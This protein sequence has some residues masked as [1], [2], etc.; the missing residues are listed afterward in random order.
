MP[1]TKDFDPAAA[2]DAAMDLFWTKGYEATS[3]DDL[4]RHLGVGR[5]SLYATFGSKH[6][7]YLRALERYR[8]TV[9]GA[10]VAQ[11]ACGA[12]IRQALRVWLAT[13]I[14]SILGDP[15][16]RGCIMVNAAAE[17][18]S[19]DPAARRCVNSNAQSIEDALHA[20]IVRA[21]QAGDVSRDKDARALAR[22]YLVTSQGLAL[23]A[24]TAERG[25]LQDT[26]EVAL[27]ALD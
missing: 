17:R 2:V 11:I 10:V 1:R 5:G 19:C 26:V 16:R 18:G 8:A 4:V 15:E 20:A 27:A 21:Q 7:L 25:T 9:G 6:Q 13:S 24:K 3:V 12:P 23:A 14:D 22:F